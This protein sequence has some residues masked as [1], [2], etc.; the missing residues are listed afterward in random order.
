MK[1]LTAEQMNS[2]DRRATSRF[3]IP[4]LVLMENAAM[5]VVDAIFEHY[6]SCERVSIFCEAGVEQRL[7]DRCARGSE[8]RR[9]AGRFIAAD[10]GSTAAG[11]D[12]LTICDGSRCRCRHRRHRLAQRGARARR[13]R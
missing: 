5:A 10:R 1:I 8:S 3:A 7:L 2:I 6:A 12:N 13:R 11:G 4:S 9:R